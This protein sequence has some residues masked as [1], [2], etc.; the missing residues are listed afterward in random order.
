M[1]I[2]LDTLPDDRATVRHMLLSV[3]AEQGALHAECDKLRLLIQRLLR[4]QFGRRS[5]QLTL[6]QLQRG[7]EDLEQVVAESEA[8]Q[9]TAAYA[10]SE[11]RKGE[12]PAAHLAGFRGVLQVHGYAGFKRLAGDR[13]DGAIKLAFCWAQAILYAIRHWPGLVVFL[14]DGRVEMDTNPVERSIRPIALD[15]KNTL[16]AGSDGG[17]RHWAVAMTLIQTGKLN[18]VEPMAYVTDVLQRMVSG[19][20]KANELHT[21]LPWNWAPVATAGLMLPEAVAA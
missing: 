8:A 7:L 3:V 17:A 14:D 9:D 21:L 19:Q 5:E 4:Q 12:R 18:G 15:R 6:D 2:D 16:F 20:T 11:D 13:K 1:Q 10:Y